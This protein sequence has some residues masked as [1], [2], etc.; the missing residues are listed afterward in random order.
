MVDDDENIRQ[1]GKEILGQYGYKVLLAEDGESALELYKKLG[2]GIDLVLLDLIMPGMGGKQ[3]LENLIRENLRIKV[4]IT[5]GYSF[6]GYTRETI[7][8]WSK[9][10]IGKPFE[11]KEIL[12]VI[13]KVLD[14]K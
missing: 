14:E 3:C 1:L 11:L 9:G 6:D 12:H 7:Q 8:K 13:R 5:T 2:E 10:I 4:I